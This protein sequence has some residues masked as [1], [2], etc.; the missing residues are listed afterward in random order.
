MWRLKD[1]MYPQLVA[2][3][4]MKVQELEDDVIPALVEMEKNGA[5]IDLELL[6]QYHRE[7]M[8][9]HDRLMTEVINEAGFAFQHNASGWAQLFERCGLKP[10]DSYAESVMDTI[11]HPLVK[12]AYL[13]GQYASL[14]SK[15]FSAYAKQV[16]SDGLLRY[17]INQL[18]G[19]DGGTVSG[20]FSIGY[21]QQVPNADNHFAIF[22]DTLFPRK[23]FISRSGLYLDADAAQIEYRIFAHF[24]NNPTVLKAYAEDPHLSFHKMTWEMIKAVK[25]DQLYTHQKSFNFARMYGAKGIKL[26]VMMDFISDAVG[27]EIRKA[28]RWNDSRLDRIKSIEA[29]Y[30]KVMP[31]VDKLLAYAAHLAKPKCDD[32]CN[33]GD[34]LHR[35]YEHRGFVKTMM[36]RR[37]R[38]K[39]N[40]KTYI[41]LN[42]VIQGTGADIMKRKLVE[43]HKERKQT[44]FLMRMT[45][46]DAVGGDAQAPDTLEKVNAILNRQSFALK[47]PIV[48]ECKTGKTWADCK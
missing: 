37:S 25:P 2:E 18:R 42:R 28:K 33:K 22:G 45:V 16:D 44:G 23:L 20:R 31:E 12:K 8:T 38:F 15:T 43:L 19:D 40:H 4:L 26:S 39:N 27:E 10:S 34:D 32:F 29:A 24:A 1:K 30:N 47:V 48:W 6:E 13:A 35:Q 5:P 36:G 46:H 11:D 17:Q 9:E 3:D 21:V 14:D 41:G 7:C